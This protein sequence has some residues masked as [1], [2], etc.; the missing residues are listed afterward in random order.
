MK[1]VPFYITLF[2]FSIIGVL[3]AI[4]AVFPQDGLT[5]GQATL[6]YPTLTQMFEQ[7][8]TL[9]E[10]PLSPE[11]LLAQRATQMRIQEEQEFLDF[12]RSNEARI[13]FPLKDGAIDYTYLDSFYYALNHADSNAVR[14]VHYGDSQIEEDRISVVLRRNLQQK[15]GGMGIGIVPL[16]QTVQSITEGIKTSQEPKRYMVFGSKSMRREGS[17]RYGPMGQTAVIDT[18][19]SITFQPRSKQTGVYSAHYFNQATLLTGGGNINIQWKGQKGTVRNDGSAMQ[20]TNLIVPDSTTNLTITL[21][22][23]G[24]IYGISLSGETGV[25]VDNIPMRGCSGTIFSGIDS[26][27]L[28]TYFSATNTRLIIMQFGG[29][30][31]PYIKTQAQADKYIGTLLTQVKYMQRQAPQAQILFIGPSDMTTRLQG[32]MQTYP[33]LPYFDEALSTAL[34]EQ[35]GVAYWSLF[36]AMGGVGAMS[37]WV[38]S[39]YAASD[40]IHFTRKGA[41]QVGEILCDALLTGYN[42]Y[43]WREKDKQP[44]E[45]LNPDS[46]NMLQEK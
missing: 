28:S 3:A 42:Y 44:I 14:V 17:K 5:I 7:D 37:T 32:K 36:E 45:Y 43:T 41:Y 33:I 15:F 19:I 11:E 27:Q 34:T 8:T 39:G 21:S 35:A 10:S 18:T 25:N 22:G 29:N 30:S 6:R 26:K 4:A 40:Y 12:F 24:D 13:Q 38:R 2:I 23:H 9:K 31:M 1:Y 20:I 46:T 16:Y